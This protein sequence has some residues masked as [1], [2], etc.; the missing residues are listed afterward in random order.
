M[1][2]REPATDYH[3]RPAVSASLLWDIASPESCLKQA[4]YNSQW[5][6]PD[7]VREKSEDMDNGTIL[8][9][10]CLEPHLLNERITIVDA[11]SWRTKEARQRREDAYANGLVPVL[12]DRSMGT[13]YRTLM[14]MRKVLEE[15]AAAPLLFGSE[16]ESEVTFTWDAWVPYS[17]NPRQDEDM[18][19]PCKARADRIL[20][21][22]YIVDLKSAPSASPTSF[23]RDVVSWGHHLRAAFYL[24]GWAMQEES[25]E[26]TWDYLFVVCSKRPPHLVSVYRLDERTQIWGQRLY[27]KALGDFKRA[28]QSGHWPDF[29][30]EPVMTVG[31][32]TYAEY[33]LADLEA[34]GVL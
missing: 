2:I 13:S 18:R 33:R 10:A 7:G 34:E 21:D 20:K 23:Q 29:A 5:L 8:H 26:K 19:I 14:E 6:N 25:A 9:L 24:D 1:L 12:A 30:T 16:G 28:W 4:W 11:D 17:E 15:S 22:R 31:L 32:P 27:R 3:A